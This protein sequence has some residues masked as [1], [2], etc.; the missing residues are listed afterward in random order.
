ML[1]CLR[2][3]LPSVNARITENLTTLNTAC[4]ER[5][6]AW[7]EN[8]PGGLQAYKNPVGDGTEMKRKPQIPE[9]D[10]GPKARTPKKLGDVVRAGNLHQTE[11]ALESLEPSE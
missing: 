1:E 6:R 9:M 3:V 10:A 2:L 11:A 5:E 4:S 7:G 8:L